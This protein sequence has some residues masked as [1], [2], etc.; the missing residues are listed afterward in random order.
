MDL[1]FLVWFRSCLAL[2]RFFA[3]G[4]SGLFLRSGLFFLDLIRV[5]HQLLYCNFGFGNLGHFDNKVDN[6]ILE[7]RRLQFLHGFRVF[8]KIP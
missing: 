4:T 2:G 1:T 6:L 3:L 7:D 8:L 5:A